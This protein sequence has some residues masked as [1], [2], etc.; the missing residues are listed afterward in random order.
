MNCAFGV[1]SKNILPKL[2]SQRFSGFFFFKSHILCLQIAVP[3]YSA[4]L[5][6]MCMSCYP[7]YQPS[8]RYRLC[9][10]VLWKP[11]GESDI[12]PTLPSSLLVQWCVDIPRCY[13]RNREERGVCGNPENRSLREFLLWSGGQGGLPWACCLSMVRRQWIL[14][15]DLVFEYFTGMNSSV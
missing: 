10:L 8:L 12:V 6:I 7:C 1:T 15:F 14:A 13:C 2:I 11:T 3:L 9:I 4:V 5:L